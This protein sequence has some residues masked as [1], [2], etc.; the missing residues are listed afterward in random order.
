MTYS[1]DTAYDAEN[2]T[3]LFMMYAIHKI[4]IYM[5]IYVFHIKIFNIHILHYG[6]KTHT[7]NDKIIDIDKTK[8]RLLILSM[9]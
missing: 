1:T 5:Y 4:Y 6:K 9:A 8:T 3:H 7:I 2:V